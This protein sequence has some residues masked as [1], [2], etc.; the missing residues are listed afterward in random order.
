MGESD[1]FLA[2][3]EFNIVHI[4]EIYLY[5]QTMQCKIMRQYYYNRINWA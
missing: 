1:P 4:V 5:Y 3:L 2:L